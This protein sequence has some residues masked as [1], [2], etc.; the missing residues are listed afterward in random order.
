MFCSPTFNALRD[1]FVA[2]DN[3]NVS[4]TG[5]CSKQT[6]VTSPPARDFSIV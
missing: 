1:S 2:D 3:Y 4:Y 5:N 6:G